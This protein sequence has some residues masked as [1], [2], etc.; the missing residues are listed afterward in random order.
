MN[1]TQHEILRALTGTYVCR[2]PD[3]LAEIQ[4]QKITGESFSS[5]HL[6]WAGGDDPSRPHYYRIQGHRLLMEYDNT[7]RNANHIHTVWR[8]PVSDFGM[9]ALSAHRRHEH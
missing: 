9:D 2:L 1:D 7:A 8:D 6:A 5:L 4:M 3:R